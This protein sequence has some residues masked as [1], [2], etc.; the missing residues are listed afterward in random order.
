MVPL[1]QQAEPQET[2][3]ALKS[4][5]DQGIRYIV[6]G[7]GSG[8]ALALIDAVE[9]HNERNPARNGVPELRRGRSRPHQQQ[10]QLL[11]L[12]P[13][14]QHR[15]EDGGADDLHEGPEG[16]QEGLPD[17]PEL[18]A[19]PAGVARSPRKTWR[20]SG[21]TSRSSATTCT[22][23]AQVRDFSPYVAKIK[24]SG[25]DTVITGNWGSDLALLVKAAHD[26]GL[27][28]K[29]YTYYAASPARPPRWAQSA[30]GKVR[31]G[32]RRLQHAG[33]HRQAGR[34]SSRPSSTT[35]TTRWRPTPRSRCSA[36]RWRRP[37]D[38]PGES[39]AGAWKA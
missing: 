32:L 19:W 7:N 5:I 38:R 9:K 27:N 36:R 28:V 34:S 22:R 3:N 24:A 37:S 2:L 20:A 15:H 17:Q 33:R 12:P 11:A 35:T 31:R 14:R 29:F 1:R 39:G 23:S 30:A 6:Q 21:R 26:A 8:A 18:L 16:H 13:R 10:V 4:L 25:A